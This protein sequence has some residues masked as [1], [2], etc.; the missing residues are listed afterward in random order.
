[1]RHPWAIRL[2]CF[3]AYHNYINS[4]YPC[5]ENDVVQLAALFME[6]TNDDFDVKKWKAYLVEYVLFKGRD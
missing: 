2:L 1:M 5:S 6:I 4:M 3:E